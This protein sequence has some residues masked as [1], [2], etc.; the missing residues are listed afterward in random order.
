MQGIDNKYY[1]KLGPPVLA[2]A[3]LT[4]HTAEAFLENL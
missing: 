4:D 1:G 2:A 3:A